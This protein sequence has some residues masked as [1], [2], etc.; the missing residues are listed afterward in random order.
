TQSAAQ[1]SELEQQVANLQASLNRTREEAA[2]VT[3]GHA[4]EAAQLRTRLDEALTHTRELEQA[5]DEARAA[6]ADAERLRDELREQLRA[7][8]ARMNELERASQSTSDA[9]SAEAARLADELARTREDLEQ[10]TRRE[11]SAQQ[12]AHEL[13]TTLAGEQE[14]VHDLRTLADGSRAALADC[15]QRLS[16]ATAELTSLRARIA[17]L[18]A[19]DTASSQA[20]REGAEALAQTRARAEALAAEA[21]LARSTIADLQASLSKSEAALAQAR[22][23]LA[24]ARAD[25]DAARAELDTL[26]AELAASRASLA[27]AAQRQSA[28]SVSSSEHER[29]IADLRDQLARAGEATADLQARIEDSQQSLA[30]R[31]EALRVLAQRLKSAETRA[32]DAEARADSAESTAPNNA[33]S[34]DEQWVELRRSRLRRQRDL[35][36]AQS[37]KL[38]GAKAAIAKRRE[39]YEEVIAQRQK[40]AAAAAALAEERKAHQAKAGRSHAAVWVLSIVASLAV[41][42]SMAWAIAGQVAPSVF[43][44]RAVIEADA[45]GGTLAQDDLLSWTAN[46]EKLA[47]DPQFFNL[48]G[49][50]FAQRAMSDLATPAAV[51]KRTK[52]DMSIMTDRAGVLTIELRGVGR[53]RTERELETLSL[54]MVALANA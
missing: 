33:R 46:H 34:H 5:A 1:A 22:E 10:A 21:E 53:E 42:F 3:A 6:H 18:S 45:K 9:A 28:D 30:A 20:A 32:A 14:Q 17:T 27:D 43:A 54:A 36:L 39:Q 38:A 26:R 23:E 11:Q 50:R 35:I 44:A 4:A 40:I 29:T 41:I 52:A 47:E 2:S 7:S 12:R 8:Q 19:A 25:L 49:E 51:M 13:A 48:A 24:S 15:E 16:A 31:D 37:R